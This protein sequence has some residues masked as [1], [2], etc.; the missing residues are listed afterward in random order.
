MKIEFKG[1][2]EPGE[3]RDHENGLFLIA[4][5]VSENALI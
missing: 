3:I 1:L 2:G 4:P 5:E